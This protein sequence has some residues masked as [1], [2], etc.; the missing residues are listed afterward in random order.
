MFEIKLF[1]F[2]SCTN[3]IRE[4]KKYYWGAGDVPRKEDDHAL[5]ELRYFIMTRPENK[6]PIPEKSEITR[7]KERKYR[8]LVNMRRGGGYFL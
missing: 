5:D 2:S 8:K 3:L 7:D 4:F 6:P 1:I